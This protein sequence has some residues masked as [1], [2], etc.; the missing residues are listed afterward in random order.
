LPETKR[1][2]LA[3]LGRP[4]AGDSLARYR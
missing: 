2:Q 4:S 1:S 3:G